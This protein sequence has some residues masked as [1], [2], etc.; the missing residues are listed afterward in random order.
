MFIFNFVFNSFAFIVCTKWNEIVDIQL[1]CTHILHVYIYIYICHSE[2]WSHEY[3]ITVTSHGRHDVWILRHRNC[4]FSITTKSTWN[5]RINTNFIRKITRLPVDS[6]HR[7]PTMWKGF[8]VM[9][10]ICVGLGFWTEYSI[11]VITNNVSQRLFT[12]FALIHWE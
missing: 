3:I 9:A 5:F 6:P 2:S 7:G 1:L 4:L 10:S 12:R 11:K 8:H